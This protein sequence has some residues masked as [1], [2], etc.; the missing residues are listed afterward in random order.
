MKPIRTLCAAVMIVLFATTTTYASGLDEFDSDKM[1]SDLESKLE[2]SSDKR[3]KLKPALDTK[4]EELKKHIHASV[5]EGFMQLGELSTQLDAASREAEAKLR[6]ALS[7][8]EMQQLK[9]YLKKIDADAIKEIRDE[10]VAQ[11]TQFL[12]LTEDQIAKVKPILEDG[13]NQLS[14]MLNRLQQE[15]RKSLEEFKSQFEGLNKELKQKLQDNLD[16]EQIKKL[17]THHEDLR[18]N[19]RTALNFN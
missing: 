8:E 13:F 12:K 4:S 5:D 11:L 1:M 6:E 2:L 10:L 7:S 16:G 18:E 3:D 17:D 15:G 9:D 14:E 19:I